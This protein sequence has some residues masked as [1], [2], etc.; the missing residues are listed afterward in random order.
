MS[1]EQAEGKALDARS[2]LFAF[3]VL[4]YEM[5]GGQRPFSGDTRLST[6]AAVLKASPD[7]LRHIR[8]DVPAQVER[9]VSRCL[10][11]TPEARYASA[12]DVGRELMAFQTAGRSRHR[13]RAV[14]VAAAGV[15]LVI[16]TLAVLAYNR[17][18][19]MN[20]VEK[21][22]VPQIAHLLA[23]DR[24]FAA[25][26]LYREAERTNPASRALVAFS[27]ALNA[28]P[29]SVQSTPPGAEVYLSDYID[30]KV[31]DASWELLGVTPLKTDRI[32]Y[33][34]YY[35][36][37]VSK[38]GFAS[39]ERPFD[40]VALGLS[41]SAGHLD[42]TL[43][44][45][46]RVPEGMI[47]V[48]AAAAG[49]A[50][51]PPL[52][53]PAVI[54]AFWLDKQEVS[55]KQFKAFVD[56]GGY[57][58]RTNWKEPFVTNGHTL[59]WDDAMSRFHD[60]TSRAGPA[61]WQLG[62]YPEGTSDLPVSGVSWYEAAA[63]C[64][65]V[66]KSLPTAYH[67][68][69]AAAG[70]GLFSTIVQLSNFG[71]HGPQ[72]VGR[73]HGL[74]QYGALDMAGNVKEW[75]A[76]PTGT[77]RAILGGSWDES[78]YTFLQLDA[79][80][81]FER[82]ATFGFRCARF[83]ERPP[84]LLSEALAEVE[85]D[86]RSEKPVDDAAFRVYAALH[87]YDRTDLAAETKSVDDSKP[88][89]RRETV[90]FRAAYGN[91]RVVAH[92]Y[93]PKNTAPPY[94]I[95]LFVP[96]GNNFYFQS[97]DTLP[98]PFEFLV[99]AGRAVLVPAV[100]GTLERGPSPLSVGPNQMRDRLLQWSKDVQRSIDYLETRAEIDTKKLAFYG[101]SYSAGVSPT[102][103]APEPRFKAAVLVSGGAWSPTA[104]EVDP[105]NY[106]PRV[107]VPVLMLNGRDDF[108]FPVD[109]AQIPLLRAL[110]TPDKDKRHVL[111][112]GG[113]VNLQ[114]RMDLIGEI[115]RWLDT[116]LGPVNTTS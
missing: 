82:R 33:A 74:S 88:Y 37:R 1:P 57:R 63:Y 40:P 67:W 81:P 38:A 48:D 56:A 93:S 46:D 89:F 7:P 100:Q 10:E 13:A 44:S 53:T 109:K 79:E 27:E 15:I 80:E 45:N 11:K 66:Q 102:L 86:R 3:G 51:G 26:K 113:H 62:T 116:H 23:E 76:S 49:A 106:A 25:L 101:I 91:D 73:N 8:R 69:H 70:V 99:R 39:I 28:P 42:L 34:G 111:F 71:A 59:Q 78:S 54:P 83:V 105:W 14:K 68:Y 90:T 96:S 98:D 60:A 17:A 115:L 18:S 114:T 104:A 55:N 64:D 2:D 6:I 108:I 61:T 41:P 16:S 84:A 77:K 103:L 4:L 72:P 5:L 20:W 95:V 47:W 35:R 65:F 112:D 21:T 94:Q 30:A 32:P 52:V 19:R 97:I 50:T 36:I 12:A 92:L 75:S 22:A 43:Q 58:T 110:G 107:K 29:L 87:R 31:G 85:T 9:I 24:P